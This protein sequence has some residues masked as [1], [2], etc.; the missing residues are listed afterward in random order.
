MNGVRSQNG[1]ENNSTVFLEWCDTL[2][3]VVYAGDGSVDP[4]AKENLFFRKKVFYFFVRHNLSL[5]RIS[6]GLVRFHH[7]DTFGYVLAVR[8]G[9][10]RSD[11]F[12]SHDFLPV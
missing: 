8:S 3:V 2:A 6:T 11:Y 7:F 4:E 9:F 10:E 5:E 1:T 12:L